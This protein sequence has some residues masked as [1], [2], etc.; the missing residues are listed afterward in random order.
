[1]SGWNAWRFADPALLALVGLLAVVVWAGLAGR[2]QSRVRFSSLAL[3]RAARGGRPEALRLLPLVARVVAVFLLV[4]AAA[5]PQG[6]TVQ[7]QVTSEGVD[8]SLVLDTSGSMEELDFQLGRRA[9]TR[10]DVV[11]RVVNDFIDRREN[12]R[13]GLVAFGE[14]ALIQCPHT[15]DYAAL[16]LTLDAV[17]LRM[18]GDG[19]AI[20]NALGMATRTLKDLPGRSRI[21]VLLTDGANTTGVLDPVAAARAAAAYGIKVYTIGVGSIPKSPRLQRFQPLDEETLRSV[22]EATGGRYFRATDTE[23]L[24]KVYE[25]IDQLE[26]TEVEVREYT[27]YH[28]LYRILLLPAV[29]LLLLDVL[30]RATWLRTLP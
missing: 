21:V 28:E 6:G 29:L 1:M 23:G 14:E 13:I 7:R 26:K 20:G 3:V 5:R 2:G 27:D 15:T 16:K 12:D 30:L 18:A 24:Q 9:A 11:K 4:V 10:L 17:H 25:L 22:A 19:T 8:I